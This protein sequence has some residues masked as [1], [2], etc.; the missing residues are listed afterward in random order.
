[1]RFLSKLLNKKTDKI[2]QRIKTLSNNYIQS[3]ALFNEH[4][5]A[6][7]EAIKAFSMSQK[8]EQDLLFL[9]IVLFSSINHCYEEFESDVFYF[10][11]VCDDIKEQMYSKIKKLIEKNDK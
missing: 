9:F 1:M 4:L 5:T 8:T 11:S 10:S 6:S 3:S 2:I 7:E